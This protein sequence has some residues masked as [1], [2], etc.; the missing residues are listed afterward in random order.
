MQY[1]CVSVQLKVN[2]LCLSDFILKSADWGDSGKGR[3][4]EVRPIPDIVPSV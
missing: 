4:R 3:G 1:V 2:S